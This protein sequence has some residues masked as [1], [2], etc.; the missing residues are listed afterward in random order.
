MYLNLHVD[1]II[2]I[3]DACYLV[4]VIV[5]IEPMLRQN[6]E[7]CFSVYGHKK[8]RWTR[9]KLEGPNSDFAG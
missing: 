5:I 7:F 9:L 6:L 2:G 8:T 4:G 3:V 1:D